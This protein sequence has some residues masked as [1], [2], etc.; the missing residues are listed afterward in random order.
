MATEVTSARNEHS[1]FFSHDYSFTQSIQALHLNNVEGSR[2]DEG[3]AIVIRRYAANNLVALFMLSETN[4]TIKHYCT[5]AKALFMQIWKDQFEALGLK[6]VANIHPFEALKGYYWYSQAK[7]IYEDSKNNDGL[8]E[9]FFNYLNQAIN[10]GDYFAGCLLL[11]ALVDAESVADNIVT[12]ESSF[13]QLALLH[14]TP[15]YLLLAN[16]YFHAA[17]YTDC[18]RAIEKATSLIELS[19]NEIANSQLTRDQIQASLAELQSTAEQRNTASLAFLAK[20]A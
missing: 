8:P 9:V 14:S 2:V 1:S 5:S 19:T 15:G 11:Q 20:G 6:P 16:L 12:V 4:P 7:A 13:Q 17:Q 10:Y 3:I 18:L